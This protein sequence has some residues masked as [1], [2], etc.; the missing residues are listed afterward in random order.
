[1]KS[2]NLVFWTKNEIYNFR[3]KLEIWTKFWTKLVILR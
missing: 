1:M 2:D 3:R